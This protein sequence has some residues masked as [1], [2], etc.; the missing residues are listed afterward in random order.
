M[1]WV[2]Q[3]VKR[4][5]LF[6]LSKTPNQRRGLGRLHSF[7]KKNKVISESHHAQ[8]FGRMIKEENVLLG[9]LWAER[10]MNVE[11]TEEAETEEHSNLKQSDRICDE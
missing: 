7:K 1:W 9:F 6:L 4:K 5:F 3:S 10:R 8:M 11:K 2:D